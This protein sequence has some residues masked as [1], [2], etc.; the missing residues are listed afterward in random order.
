MVLY[1]KYIFCICALDAP[2]KVSAPDRCCKY[3]TRN[4]FA[5]DSRSIVRNVCHGLQQKDQHA[6][7]EYFNSS[8]NFDRFFNQFSLLISGFYKLSFET[9]YVIIYSVFLV[10]KNWPR[11]LQEL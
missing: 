5:N 2:L 3:F 8:P 10:H 7:L 11:A 4:H 1:V 6:Y 9:S